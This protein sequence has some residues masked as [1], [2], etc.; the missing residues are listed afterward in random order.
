VNEVRRFYP[1]IPVIDGR[2]RHS[3][4]WRGK[5]FGT[6]DWVMLDLYATHHD[7]RL[8][9][10]PNR[11]HPERFTDWDGDQSTLIT[12][13]AG[14][15]PGGQRI[16][17]EQATIDLMKEAVILL[18]ERTT[19]AV[20]QQDLRISLRRFPALPKSGFALENAERR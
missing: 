1:F 17:G 13:G 4:E 2:V 6:D 5:S 15:V 9:K 7:A 14:D 11:F 3:F 8:W 12:Q 16:P 19:Y 18:A 10:E 20:P